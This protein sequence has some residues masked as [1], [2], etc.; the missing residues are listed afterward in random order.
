MTGGGG[1]AAGR[2]SF[3]FSLISSRND[4]LC[5]SFRLRAP[6][7]SLLEL[8]LRERYSGL[9]RRVDQRDERLL[10]LVLVLLLVRVRLLCISL[11]LLLLELDLR[12]LLA[13]SLRLD[14]DL[15]LLVDLERLRDLLCLR[16]LWRDRDRERFLTED[17]LSF[18]TSFLELSQLSM[19][20]KPSKK[21][22]FAK[23]SKK[24]DGTSSSSSSSSSSSVISPSST[25]FVRFRLRVGVSWVC[26]VRMVFSA[27]ANR[28]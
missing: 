18:G 1:G 25:G 3:N 23:S 14:P 24:S 20:S 17:G 12:L 6:G 8:R 27:S 26:P 7:L 11:L 4:F 5:T 22:S 21:S 28:R 15:D 2:T 19:I 10:L 13:R 16:C 9:L